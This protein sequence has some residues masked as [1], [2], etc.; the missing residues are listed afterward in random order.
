MSMGR[1]DA[2]GLRG[3]RYAGLPSLLNTVDKAMRKTYRPLL[4]ESKG[5]FAPNPTIRSLVAAWRGIVHLLDG[6]R[7]IHI[8]WV[9]VALELLHTLLNYFRAKRPGTPRRFLAGLPQPPS[10][11][12]LR[13]CT[14]YI[15]TSQILL[16][17]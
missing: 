14:H 15:H 8:I 11:I 3:W 5:I 16:L 6:A 1:L 13:A 4:W 10:I 17:A 12:L 9:S 7:L 2:D